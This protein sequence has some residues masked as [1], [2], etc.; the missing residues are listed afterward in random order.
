MSTTTTKNDNA[1]TKW[2][3]TLLPLY[4]SIRSKGTESLN[5]FLYGL[6][7]AYA[8]CFRSFLY[9]EL[10]P[11]VAGPA[12]ISHWKRKVL[13]I[14]FFAS[15]YRNLPPPP[16][17]KFPSNQP[18]AIQPLSAVPSS[19]CPSPSAATV[20]ESSG[21]PRAKLLPLL[22]R[23]PMIECLPTE[24]PPCAVT[25]NP[26]FP[27]SN[28]EL[29]LDG[30]TSMEPLNVLQIQ[31]EQTLEVPQ[32]LTPT[33]PTEDRLT[34]FQKAASGWISRETEALQAMST[35]PP[36]Q[37]GVPT[38]K[39]NRE[40]DDGEAG[41]LK[42]I[43]LDAKETYVIDRNDMPNHCVF[44]PKEDNFLQETLIPKF[45]ARQT[46]TTSMTRVT[47]DCFDVFL[48]VYPQPGA[49]SAM[50]LRHKQQMKSQIYKVIQNRNPGEVKKQRPKV[51]EIVKPKRKRARNALEQYMVLRCKGN[52]EFKKQLDIERT[53]NP[54]S[55]KG[56]GMVN[57]HSDPDGDTGGLSLGGNSSQ[58]PQKSHKKVL[59]GLSVQ[60]H[61]QVAQRLFDL[62]PPEV[63]VEM[64]RLVISDLR[65]L[66][67]Q[68]EDLLGMIG[69]S[70]SFVAGGL[71]PDNDVPRTFVMN[72]G[73]NDTGQD[74]HD[75][76]PDFES[77]II[78]TKEELPVRED[79][80]EE[81]LS[82]E[83]LAEED[84]ILGAFADIF[85]LP[86]GDKETSIHGNTPDVQQMVATAIASTAINSEAPRGQ[87]AEIS[88]ATVSPIQLQ[89][90][91]T[92]RRFNGLSPGNPVASFPVSPATAPIFSDP[93]RLPDQPV[94]VL[95]QFDEA[96]EGSGDPNNIPPTV[97]CAATARRFNGP[98]PGNPAAP[99]LISPV[100]AAIFPD[101]P[102]FS[103][104]PNPILPQFGEALDGPGDPNNVAGDALVTSSL[105][106][107]DS[108]WQSF[109]LPVPP[110]I[111]SEQWN[112]GGLLP[113][114]SEVNTDELDLSFMIADTTL[115]L[116]DGNHPTSMDV[117]TADS[118]DLQAVLDAGTA[119]F[120]QYPPTE[121]CN[122]AI[123]FSTPQSDD[124]THIL[125]HNDGVDDVE[126]DDIESAEEED[127]T[128]PRRAPMQKEVSFDTEAAES[129]LRSLNLGASFA[130]CVDL[131]K[132]FEQCIT[133][134]LQP[135]RWPAAL[136][137]Y[138]HA[139][140]I[141]LT[142]PNL[143]LTSQQALIS[144]ILLWWNVL[145]PA[146]HQTTQV[147]ALPVADY[148]CDLSGLRKKGSRGML[149]IMY[150]MRWW[151]T[152]QL[153]CEKWEAFVQDVSSC[154]KTMLEG[155]GQHKRKAPSAAPPR[156]RIKQ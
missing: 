71:E 7:V 113:E 73:W 37:D 55:S 82:A 19:P 150:A 153:E 120:D 124:D 67:R 77:D 11:P 132:S 83:A 31:V 136:S 74:F 68:I 57:D 130:S 50:L 104:Q 123:F 33:A 94:P 126:D 112:P 92:A 134:R 107:I 85:G 54:S 38:H 117:T 127:S 10:G 62:E 102:D 128:Q 143:S 56:K 84:A 26:T 152:F 115:F 135:G 63:Q 4:C 109:G 129:M 8:A 60:V 9:T 47:K 49:T 118:D 108:F 41:L 46:S 6:F 34:I 119:L 42:R 140:P 142:L 98:S 149:Q 91:T 97:Q 96:L 139:N 22:R 1:Q 148:S 48:D 3:Q 52:P 116:S 70:F 111:W 30:Q 105:S 88:S 39:R 76:H 81:P 106:D 103:G 2:A 27:A 20:P 25:S 78:Q 14:S 87:P 24:T 90:V 93:P 101:P 121:L 145:Q 79:G 44:P 100:I 51:E 154:F 141:S 137:T 43:C 86:S 95:P 28:S 151:G 156:K 72:Y 5:A 133:R 144:E 80:T 15:I 138:L 61:R 110:E 89:R 64:Q 13:E 155:S 32:R 99:F 65:A 53:N 66:M 23:V 59:N 18:S 17:S 45:E 36:E 58:P 12:N 146:T 122:D 147:D 21:P 29:V 40:D 69:W 131:W 75:F 35:V 16:S 125:D 114:T